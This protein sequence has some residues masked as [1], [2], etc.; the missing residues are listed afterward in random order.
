VLTEQLQNVKSAQVFEIEKLKD[1]LED[2]TEELA[3]VRAVHSL[4]HHGPFPCPCF[5]F[6]GGVQ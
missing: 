4:L 6:G 2:T 1:K 3:E 5:F